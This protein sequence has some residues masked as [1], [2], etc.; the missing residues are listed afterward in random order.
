MNSDVQTPPTTLMATLPSY[1]DVPL[2]QL[3]GTPIHQMTEEQC[4]AHIQAL[5]RLRAPPVLASELT[6]EETT[7]TGKTPRPRKMAQPIDPAKL[8]QQFGISL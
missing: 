6:R 5:R 2:A 1:T 7:L 4:R 3:L 8:A